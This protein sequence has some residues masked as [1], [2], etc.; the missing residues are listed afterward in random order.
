[1]T[2]WKVNNYGLYLIDRKSGP[3][4]IQLD[5]KV[6]LSKLPQFFC[7]G[8]AATTQDPPSDYATAEHIQ[9]RYFAI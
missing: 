8:G 3:S 2:A 7:E 1:M 6:D 9:L 4:F 5:E